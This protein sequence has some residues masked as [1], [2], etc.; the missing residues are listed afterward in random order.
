MKTRLKRIDNFIDSLQDANLSEAQSSFIFFTGGK[1]LNVKC[2]NEEC[3]SNP[4]C[5]HDKKDT[6]LN[7]DCTDSKCTRNPVCKKENKQSADSLRYNHRCIINA[8]LILCA[9]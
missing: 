7:Q 5:L 1:T 2:H 3:V 9:K 4:K 8:D 6:I